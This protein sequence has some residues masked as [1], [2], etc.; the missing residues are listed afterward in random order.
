MLILKGCDP[1]LE[2]LD[3]FASGVGK[4]IETVPEL[5]EDALQPVAKES[6][7]TI[8]LIPRVINA[9]LANV[10]IWVANQEY[11][12]AETEK[13]LAK[14]LENIDPEKIVSP[15][16]YVAVPALQAI[17][18]S[19][20]CIEL[21]ELYANLLAHSMYEDTKDSVHPAFVELIKQM[22][23]LDA[24]VFKEIMEKSVNP[25]INII[26]RSPDG[27]FHRLIQNVTD[28]TFAPHELVSVSIE[29][30]KRLNLIYIP[31]DG[32]YKNADHYNSIIHGE[33]YKLVESV[34]QDQCPQNKLD[35]HKKQIHKTDFGDSFY[36]MCVL[37][38]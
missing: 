15:E 18:Y 23:P 14:K 30:L 1:M 22:S 26:S 34:H 4:A 2:G 21:R 35:Y 12:I 20:D 32:Y 9:S 3:K 38:P 25:C 29:N 16:P 31:E 5:Y 19:V 11:K 24:K 8:A 13:L 37:A 33:I 17:S 27:S 28:I 10:R 7:K 36:K 6:G